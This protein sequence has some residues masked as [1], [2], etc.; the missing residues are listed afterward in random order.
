MVAVTIVVVVCSI[1]HSFVGVSLCVCV[2]LFGCLLVARLV[3][4]S[5]CLFV[6]LF[7]CVFDTLWVSV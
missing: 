6:C 2:R 7:V 3:G 1:I 5:V 4:W